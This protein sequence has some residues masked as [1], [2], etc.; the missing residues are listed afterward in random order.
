MARF[1]LYLLM[2]LGMAA[3]FLPVLLLFL[4]VHPDHRMDLGE[5]GLYVC[6]G[7]ETWFGL[8]FEKLIGRVMT[9]GV[10]GRV[11]RWMNAGDE[12]IF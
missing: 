3:Q 11:R 4:Q 10:S 5:L 6:H 2:I 8:M 7:R 12:G 9:G 1:H